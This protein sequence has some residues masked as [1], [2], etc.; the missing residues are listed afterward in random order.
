MST[1]LRARFMAELRKKMDIPQHIA[2]QA[3]EKNGLSMPKGHFH[4][5]KQWSNTWAGTPI[6]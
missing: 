4:R 3:F 2:K 6:K 5:P 1:V